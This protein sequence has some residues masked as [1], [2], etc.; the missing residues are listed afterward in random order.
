MCANLKILFAH[1][2]FI[3]N[4]YL[5][6]IIALLPLVFAPAPKP[7]TGGPPVP[8]TYAHGSTPVPVT[9][10]GSQSLSSAGISGVPYLF[11]IGSSSGLFH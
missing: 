9:P 1:F 7:T 8:S 4:M 10:K 6:L 11:P 5:L 2:S 3:R